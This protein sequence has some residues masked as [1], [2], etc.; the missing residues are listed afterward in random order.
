MKLRRDGVTDRQAGASGAAPAPAPRAIREPGRETASTDGITAP[1]HEL[2]P[3]RLRPWRACRGRSQDVAVQLAARAAQRRCA[4]EETRNRA[5]VCARRTRP[6]LGLRRIGDL[7]VV[8]KGDPEDVRGLD[9]WRECPRHL[10]G[11]RCGLFRARRYSS[12][13][14]T[15]SGPSRVAR[16]RGRRQPRHGGPGSIPRARSRLR[17]CSSRLTGE[18]RL[19]VACGRAAGSSVRLT[20]RGC[21]TDVADRSAAAL[22]SVMSGPVQRLPALPGEYVCPSRPYASRVEDDRGRRPSRDPSAAGAWFAVSPR[23]QL[24]PTPSRFASGSSP[25]REPERDRDLPAS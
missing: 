5:L 21:A 2:D 8:V 23:C 1:T 16:R 17:A 7:V 4:R 19:S 25:V 3:T 12:M 6:S 10:R 9:P 20:H 24:T 18:R 14:D 22:I 11:A 13:N 15:C